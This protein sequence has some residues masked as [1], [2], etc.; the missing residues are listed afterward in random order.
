MTD[1]TAPSRYQVTGFTETKLLAYMFALALH[2]DYF[3]IDA[4]SLANDLGLPPTK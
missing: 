1:A 2:L 4:A 3:T